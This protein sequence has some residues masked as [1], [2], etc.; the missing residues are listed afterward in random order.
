MCVLA[1]AGALHGVATI[2]QVAVWNIYLFGT[3]LRCWFLVD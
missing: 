1:S 2:G 3:R